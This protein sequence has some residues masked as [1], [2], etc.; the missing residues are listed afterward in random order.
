[1]ETL[2]WK[3]DTT[4]RFLNW[5]S[6]LMLHFL[7][8]VSQLLSIFHRSKTKEFTFYSFNG[9]LLLLIVFSTVAYIYG[10]IMQS[11]AIEEALKKW[12]TEEMN[13]LEI[14]FSQIKS[15]HHTYGSQVI[16]SPNRVDYIPP[17][18]ILENLE[19]LKYQ[20]NNLPFTA[21]F[22]PDNSRTVPT[23][24]VIGFF[25]IVAIVLLWFYFLL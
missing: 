17:F 24:M 14:P 7:L 22:A 13:Q 3:I 9:L 6:P 8:L 1:M 12:G 19:S 5:F 16:T 2:K 10:A 23:E 4:K 15:L 18:A 25:V 20:R 21:Y 11:R